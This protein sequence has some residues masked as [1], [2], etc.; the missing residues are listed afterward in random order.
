MLEHGKTEILAVA[1]LL[2]FNISGAGTEA[3]TC[4]V[5]KYFKVYEICHL[6]IAFC[7]INISL[8]IYR[9]NG[10]FYQSD[11]HLYTKDSIKTCHWRTT[12]AICYS[13]IRLSV[14]A[15]ISNTSCIA[16]KPAF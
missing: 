14:I 3:N 5:I 8:N 2:H 12:G 6:T 15:E 1:S 9:L 11:S 4:T 16:W 13:K 10:G 7:F